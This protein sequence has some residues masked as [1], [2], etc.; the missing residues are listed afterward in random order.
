LCN[1]TETDRK[2]EIMIEFKIEIPNKDGLK[3][4]E[5]DD[6]VD[7]F[8]STDRDDIINLLNGSLISYGDLNISI[9]RT[10]RHIRRK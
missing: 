8:L 2:E 7:F 1:A 10:L 5:V 6:V 9:S 4:K 3:D